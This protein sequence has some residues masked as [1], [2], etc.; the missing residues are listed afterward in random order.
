MLARTCRSYKIKP[1][2][3]AATQGTTGLTELTKSALIVGAFDLS[4]LWMGVQTF[5]TGRAVP[6]LGEPP[7][8]R[9]ASQVVL[10]EKLTSI[11]FLTKAPEPVLT[12]GGKSLPVSR[13]CR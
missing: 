8:L 12:H 4:L 6:I 7:A 11:P 9:H 2:A 10:V 5:V 1:S 3:T 13:M